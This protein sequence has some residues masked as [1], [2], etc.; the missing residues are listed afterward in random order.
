M[1]QDKL[2]PIKISGLKGTAQA[3]YRFW[4]RAMYPIGVVS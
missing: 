2:E 1:P 3:V 4:L